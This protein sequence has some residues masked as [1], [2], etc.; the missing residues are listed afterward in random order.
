MIDYCSI[1]GLSVVSKS[2]SR[3]QSHQIQRPSDHQVCNDLKHGEW[4]IT[5]SLVNSSIPPMT[6]V[7]VHQS[8]LIFGIRCVALPIHGII[9]APMV[10]GMSVLPS[11]VWH[12]NSLV[13]NES[14]KV[15]ECLTWRKGTMST[16]MG[17]DPMT[18]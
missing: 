17:K 11:E 1:Q 15:I 8:H 13:H 3:C 18:S 16:L 2:S 6:L 4:S 7:A 12:Q 10:L 9:S 5:N 14:P